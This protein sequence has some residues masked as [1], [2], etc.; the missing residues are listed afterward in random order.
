MVIIIMKQRK[1]QNNHSYE[2][3]NIYNIV[4]G[5]GPKRQFIRTSYKKISIKNRFDFG[6]EDKILV[7]NVKGLPIKKSP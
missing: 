3:S 4:W 1:K 2:G 6:K 7:R 5:N